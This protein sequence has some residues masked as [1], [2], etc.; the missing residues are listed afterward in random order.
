MNPSFAPRVNLKTQLVARFEKEF[1]DAQG[2]NPFPF[3]NSAPAPE[4]VP[5]AMVSV[6]VEG[7]SK[8]A[9]FVAESCLKHKS[10]RPFHV[11]Q[12]EAERALL[13]KLILAKHSMVTA[14]EIVRITRQFIVTQEIVSKKRENEVHTTS[15]IEQGEKELC[16]AIHNFYNWKAFLY[17]DYAMKEAVARA[18]QQI[19]ED[20]EREK[21]IKRLD[22]EIESIDSMASI[23]LLMKQFIENNA[24]MIAS[25]V[26]RVDEW[27]K[28]VARREEKV[29]SFEAKLESLSISIE[30]MKGLARKLDNERETKCEICLERYDSDDHPRAELPCSHEFC[31]PCI[32]AVQQTADPRQP[33]CPHC[34]KPFTGFEVIQNRQDEE[35][36]PRRPK[37]KQKK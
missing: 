31:Q 12:M 5:R 30:K 33:T 24:D 18:R 11:A 16:E 29:A 4:N 25:C 26:A 10:L 9:R 34:R 20:K 32:L 35:E 13:Y 36:A 14:V 7:L 6:V 15:S 21:E 19:I 8:G 2:G 27:E 37:K 22:A 17:E 28:N 23:N 3:D 1:K